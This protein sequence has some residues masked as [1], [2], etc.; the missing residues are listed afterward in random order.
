M[1]NAGIGTDQTINA[2]HSKIEINFLR[3]I[4][5]PIQVSPAKIISFII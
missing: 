5:P 3:M 2:R 1:A 4:L